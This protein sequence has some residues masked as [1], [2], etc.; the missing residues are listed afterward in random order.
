MPRG[1]SE[2][3]A[4]REHSLVE[5]RLFGTTRVN[6]EGIGLLDM[7]RVRLPT[8]R[9]PCKESVTVDDQSTMKSCS[10]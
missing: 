10:R 3:L 2:T 7:T 9:V 4:M 6:D 5:I 1:P 8:A